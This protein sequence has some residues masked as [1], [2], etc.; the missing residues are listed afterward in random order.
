[1]SDSLERWADLTFDELDGYRP[2]PVF[3]WH[4]GSLRAA[5]VCFAVEEQPG[6][7]G[8]PRDGI[9]LVSEILRHPTLAELTVGIRYAEDLEVTLQPLVDLIAAAPRPSLRSLTLMANPHDDPFAWEDANHADLGDLSGLW[10]KL[11]ALERLIV[12]QE[13]VQLVDPESCQPGALSLPRLRKLELS[14]VSRQ[15]LEALAAVEWPSLESVALH[16]G[17]SVDGWEASAEELGGFLERLPRLCD[18]AI[19]GLDEDELV[20]WL[21]S[22]LVGRQL[23]TLSLPRQEATA[24]VARVAALPALRNVKVDAGPLVPMPPPR[25]PGDELRPI[26]NRREWRRRF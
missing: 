16:V 7:L 12:H 26:I 14:L 24:S 20:E 17:F 25:F 5:R 18:L 1:M 10:H 6:L 8:V 3:E 19:G 15:S 4:D 23:H 11:P 21:G 13:A 2:E 22:S 9:A